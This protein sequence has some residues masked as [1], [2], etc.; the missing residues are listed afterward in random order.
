M[1]SIYNKAG[2]LFAVYIPSNPLDVYPS[3]IR[4]IAEFESHQVSL[5]DPIS[6]V[7]TT[8]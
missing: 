2:Q 4:S 1:F 3:I 6:Y 8:L 5:T 7:D